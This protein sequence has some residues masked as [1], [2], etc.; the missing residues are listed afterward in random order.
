VVQWDLEGEDV[1][2]RENHQANIRYDSTN[3]DSDIE[4]GKINAILLCTVPKRVDGP[5]CTD[6]WNVLV[7]VSAVNRIF[8]FAN[9]ILLRW[10]RKQ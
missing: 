2:K 8:N 6:G 5:T 1:R 9:H 7:V 3:R 10:P 4:F